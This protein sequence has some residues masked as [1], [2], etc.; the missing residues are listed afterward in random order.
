VGEEGGGS[1]QS[2]ITVLLR[3]QGEGDV[4]VTWVKV[5]LSECVCFYQPIIPSIKFLKIDIPKCFR[6]IQTG[7]MLN[8]YF[9]VA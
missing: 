4:G 7:M 8:Q 5:V 3:A 9:M 6:L 1:G 2:C